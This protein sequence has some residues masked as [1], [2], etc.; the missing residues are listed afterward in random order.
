MNKTNFYE[1][2]SLEDVLHMTEALVYN[3]MKNEVNQN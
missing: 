1:D 3:K 2:D